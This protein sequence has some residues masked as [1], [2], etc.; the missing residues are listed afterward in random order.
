VLQVSWQ[1]WTVLLVVLAVMVGTVVW[2][3]LPGFVD[4]LTR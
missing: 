1:R 4:A 2:R 3:L